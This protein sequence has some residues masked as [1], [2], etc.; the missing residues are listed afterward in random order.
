MQP[1]KAFLAGILLINGNSAIVCTLTVPV[2]SQLNSVAKLKL[3]LRPGYGLLI[4]T[5]VHW[6]RLVKNIGWAN[7]NIG[8]KVVKSD[9]CM[10]V[11]QLLGARARAAP[12]KVYA[13]ASAN[14]KCYST[15]EKLQIC[16]R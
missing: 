4:N 8:G 7:R 11:S 5:S 10:G 12:S 6:R 15:G 14:T 9:K 2:T 13:Y 3:G 16:S 1:I